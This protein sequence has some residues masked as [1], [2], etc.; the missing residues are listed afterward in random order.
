MFDGNPLC[1]ALENENR[2]NVGPVR[3]WV[4]CQRPLSRLWMRYQGTQHLHVRKYLI[5]LTCQLML[6]AEQFLADYS[7]YGAFERA[8][9]SNSRLVEAVNY[10]CSHHCARQIRCYSRNYAVRMCTYKFG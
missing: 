4:V 1:I 8:N 2:H 10:G 7:V 3:L 6:A 9:S 5:L